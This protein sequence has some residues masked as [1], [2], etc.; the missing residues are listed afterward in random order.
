MTTLK[1]QNNLPVS[2]RSVVIGDR[3]DL[4][5]HHIQMTKQFMFCVCSLNI[6]FVEQ[7][8]NF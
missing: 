8:A 2:K 6:S 4:S 1:W 7:L 5:Q 3:T